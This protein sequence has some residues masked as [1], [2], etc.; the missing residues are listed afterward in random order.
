MKISQMLDW[1]VCYG[2]DYTARI[3]CNFV[4]E[5][6]EEEARSLQQWLSEIIDWLVVLKPIEEVIEENGWVNADFSNINP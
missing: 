1:N 5:V 6:S 3:D 2:I 4:L